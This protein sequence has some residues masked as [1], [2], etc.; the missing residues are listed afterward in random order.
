MTPQEPDDKLK[1][2]IIKAK[3]ITPKLV[4]PEI[5]I[6]AARK[7]SKN[8]DAKT[9]A[10]AKKNVA[11]DSKKRPEIVYCDESD[12]K[13][14]SENE[15]DSSISLKRPKK[16]VQITTK[17]D[18]QPY[19]QQRPAPQQT[20]QQAPS[21]AESYNVFG[22]GSSSVAPMNFESMNDLF[23]FQ[24]LLSAQD[25]ERSQINARNIFFQ[26]IAVNCNRKANDSA[27]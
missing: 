7:K 24:Q 17:I 6:K 11:K 1:K 16:T 8:L 14:E 13:L 19:E 23:A 18:K 12:E 2:F 3:V 4:I 27:K 20:Q 10:D 26:R 15:D 5:D 22:G 21:A 25:L 9:K